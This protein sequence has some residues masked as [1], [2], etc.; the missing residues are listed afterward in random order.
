MTEEEEFEFRLR[1]EREQAAQSAMPAKERTMVHRVAEEAADSIVGGARNTRNLVGGL[2]R[3]AGSIGAT[4]LAPKDALEGL[5]ARQMGAPELA[6]QDRR[7]AMDGGL[8]EMGAD[9]DS[10]LYKGGKLGGEIAGTAGTGNLIARGLTA[11]PGAAAKAPAIIDAIRTSG[12]TAGGRTGLASI[13]ARMVGGGVTGGAAATLVNPDD[14]PVGIGIGATL[15]AALA[16]AGKVG[17]AVGPVL[18]RGSAEKAAVRNVAKAL[19]PKNAQQAAADIQTY[20]PKGAQKIP[21]SAAGITGN[22]DVAQIEQASRLRNPAQWAGF[23]ERQGRAVF[24]NV[25][26]ATKEAG[27][28]GARMQ[29]RRDNWTAAWQ[30]ASDAQKPRIWNQRM[31]QLGGDLEQALQ[32]PQASNPAVRSLLE[33]VRDE[34]I[35][36]GK[37]FSPGHLQQIRANL[38]GKSNPMSTDVFKSAPRDAPAVRD[39]IRE[40]DDILNVSTGGKWQKVVQGYAQDSAGV[41][42]AKAAQKIR[43]SYIDDATGR[44]RGGATVDVDG[45]IP[46]ITQAGLNRALDAA[47]LPD[48]TLAL[49]PDA[50]QQLMA[51]LDALRRQGV[52]QNLKRTA[53][54]GGGSDT[55]PNAMAVGATASGIPGWLLQAAN[56][57]RKVATG[58]TDTETARLL[59]DPDSLATALELFAKPQQPGRIGL[60]ASRS[61]PIL[62]GQGDGQ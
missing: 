51:T 39:L 13:P 46:R 23:D 60:T 9:P 44:V 38:Q 12:M 16:V 29:A 3:G 34:V 58:R 33:A 36:V 45:D 55:V 54:A 31:G 53:T 25:M 47:R 19:G 50:N 1:Y 41:H 15:P 62:A 21:V 52:V 10:L 17:Q 59:M 42:Q 8:E 6:P 5:I 32:S 18:F 2:V 57:G 7:A 40:M 22:M 43:N 49:S 27:D 24:D 37:G 14:A 26:D 28:L 20:Y 61:L 48:K 11:I 30:K 4:L 56:I 35:R